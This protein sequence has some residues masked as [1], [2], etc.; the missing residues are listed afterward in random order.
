MLYL[1]V[2]NKYINNVYNTPNNYS[3]GF[4]LGIQEGMYSLVK[5]TNGMKNKTKLDTTS[6]IGYIDNEFTYHL[7]DTLKMIPMYGIK[8]LTSNQENVKENNGLKVDK[9]KQWLLK[10]ELGVKLEKLINYKEWD[11]TLGTGLIYTLNSGDLKHKLKGSYVSSLNK[12]DLVGDEIGKNEGKLEFGIKAEKENI[13][14]EIG[15][16]IIKSDRNRE[17]YCGFMG[18]LVKI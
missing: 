5:N 9:N 14:Y 15:M 11:L 17:E 8:I 3:I 4:G 7:N 2:H 1:G 13:S 6:F 10:N 16:N 18:V 12:I